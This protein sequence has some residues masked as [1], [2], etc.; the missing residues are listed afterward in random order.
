VSAQV[1]ATSAV[2]RGTGLNWITALGIEVRRCPGLVSAQIALFWTG[3]AKLVPNLG[4]RIAAR[5]AV[6]KS[7]LNC[8]RFPPRPSRQCLARREPPFQPAKWQECAQGGV[9]HGRDV[10]HTDQ[11]PDGAVALT[12]LAGRRPTQ[13]AP[14]RLHVAQQREA[15]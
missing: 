15:A 6:I 13:Q 1:T 2:P 9:I 12:A 5:R 11:G 4:L 3:N 14:G 10:D 8:W 7:S